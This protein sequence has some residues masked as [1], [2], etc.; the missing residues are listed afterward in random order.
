M[1]ILLAK[2]LQSQ[3]CFMWADLTSINA[4]PLFQQGIILVFILAGLGC[5]ILNIALHAGL[6]LGS[7]MG[8][9]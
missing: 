3:V 9:Q 7:K 4:H 2:Y 1:V 8:F 6:I 5:N